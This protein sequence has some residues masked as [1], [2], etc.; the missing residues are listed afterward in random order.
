M[1]LSP[2][3]PTPYKSRN[4]IKHPTYGTNMVDEDDDYGDGDL[5]DTLDEAQLSQLDPPRPSQIP[6]KPLL[7]PPPPAAPRMQPR[8][9]PPPAPAPSQNPTAIRRIAPP[10][11]PQYGTARPSGILRPAQP[12]SS[13]SANAGAGHKKPPPPPLSVVKE[14]LQ[15][16]S[17]LQRVKREREPDNEELNPEVEDKE[18]EE[19]LPAIQLDE[20]G[21]GYRADPH[22]GVTVT[23]SRGAGRGATRAGS[24]RVMQSQ[25][26][27]QQVQ[28]LDLDDVGGETERRGRSPV[29]P[30]GNIADGAMR[31]AVFE[32]GRGGPA[33]RAASVAAH[34]PSSVQPEPA[35]HTRSSAVAA[36]TGAGAAAEA[37]RRELEELRKERANLRAALAASQAAR[38][39]LQ[40]EVMT[41]T[42]ENRIVRGKLNKA[43]AAHA[44]AIKQEQRDRQE[45]QQQLAQKEK[46]Y[47]A[48]MTVMKSDDAFRRQES[49]TASASRRPSSSHRPSSS[50][51][52]VGLSS[53]NSQRFYARSSTAA[54]ISPSAGRSRPDRASSAHPAH[55]PPPPQPVFGAGGSGFNAS[56]SQ[57]LQRGG[58]GFAPTAGVGASQRGLEREGSMGPPKVGGGKKGKDKEQGRDSKD[59]QSR[60]KGEGKT[61]ALVEDESFFGPSTAG[62][63]GSYGGGMDDT[64]FDGDVAMED[65][66]NEGG[67]EGEEGEQFPWDWVPEEKDERVELLAAV[68]AHTTFTAIEAEPAGPPLLATTKSQHS[69]AR[70][71]NSGSTFP[72]FARASVPPTFAASSSRQPNSTSMS[73]SLS[74]SSGVTAIPPPPPAPPG[75]F[76]TLHA[77]LN[78]RFPSITPTRLSQHYELTA[79]SLFTLLGRRFEPTPSHPPQH[80]VTADDLSLSLAEHLTTLLLI[81]DIARLPGPLTALLKLISSLVFLFPDFARA[82]N[83]AVGE[84]PLVVSS[85][86]T[87]PPLSLAGPSMVNSTG[88]GTANGEKKKKTMERIALLPLLGRLTARYGRPDPPAPAAAS[89]SSRSSSSLSSRPLRSRKARIVRP[90][91]SSSRQNDSAAAAKEGGQD[92]VDRVVGLEK[93]RKERLLGGVLGV[94]EG[95]AWRVAGEGEKD[96]GGKGV[97]EGEEAC[98]YDFPSCRPLVIA[99]G[100]GLLTW[101]SSGSF[102]DF[103]RSTGAVATLLDPHQ[104]TGTLLAAVQ[105]MGLF[106][107]RP[108]LFRPLLGTKFYDAPDTRNSKLPFVDRIATLLAMP[109]ADD[110]SNH[111]HS[112]TLALFSLSLR[113]LTKHEDAIVLVAQSAAFVPELLGRL[114]KDV[115][116]VWEW[117]GREVGRVAGVGLKRTVVRISR[118]LH[119]FYYLTHAPHSS[120]TISDLL[121]GGPV[122]GAEQYR[123][124]YQYQLQAINDLFM[125]ALGTLAFATLGAGAGGSG[126][127]EEGALPSWAKE[128]GFEGERARLV[129]LG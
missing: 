117:D 70:L 96:G 98:A 36:H 114:Y 109:R 84:A 28:R 43:E 54:P 8:P 90:Q 129:E 92:M 26:Q 68:F 12:P 75:P 119:L 51:S 77:L 35:P 108:T 81:L 37:E 56:Q 124:Q 44:A 34:L 66:T 80:P 111:S 85:S 91:A 110:S 93:G 22:R 64:T 121:T 62:M 125:S 102:I 101:R 105:V 42:G 50:A 123:R 79:R 97:E 55:P 2:C 122:P 24:G 106:A 83:L 100:N 69:H 1:P 52:I 94:V 118:S 14:H 21:R 99:A 61:S 41:K 116:S 86:S 78:F 87:G 65:G 107:C 23:G 71:S 115:R 15:A 4:L 19:D 59:A 39:E 38:A 57:K 126:E 40:N 74:S 82:C 3:S 120:L 67:A 18:E 29:V 45:L 25:A 47:K 95:M 58:A 73:R 32:T 31:A 60:G 89:T 53:A 11:P 88:A 63:D 27:V 20:S 48:A 76:P 49:A 33:G 13:S 104:P 128:E 72:T 6:P 103:V 9:I 16:P 10:R 5:W 112:L 30:P 127:D 46:D 7:P 17:P 113:L